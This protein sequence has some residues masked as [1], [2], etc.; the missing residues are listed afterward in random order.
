MD[1][2]GGK[3][4]HLDADRRLKRSQSMSVVAI[5]TYYHVL[6]SLVYFGVIEMGQ[7][8]RVCVCDKHGVSGIC[9]DPHDILG[10]LA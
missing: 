10:A 3:T 4:G 9:D 1:T 6:S 2:V 8:K 7:C 5:S